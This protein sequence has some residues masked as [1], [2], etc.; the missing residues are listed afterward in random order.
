M[1]IK[2]MFSLKYINF[3]WCLQRWSLRLLMSLGMLPASP[4]W[5]QTVEP[6]TPNCRPAIAP[7]QKQ[8]IVSYGSLMEDE[9]R[10]RPPI[11]RSLS[12]VTNK[13]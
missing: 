8:Y 2:A 13:Q 5:S 1:N 3:L 10:H 4:V 12:H 7:E 11:R 6:I 9:S